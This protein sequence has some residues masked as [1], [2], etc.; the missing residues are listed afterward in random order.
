MI[1]ILLV[2]DSEF[3]CRLTIEA[4][5]DAKLC[6]KIHVVH[7]GEKALEFLRRPGERPDLLCMH[8]VAQSFAQ[9]RRLS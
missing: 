5:K 8:P 2:D 9:R 7:D 6:N 4:P 3:D 1:E